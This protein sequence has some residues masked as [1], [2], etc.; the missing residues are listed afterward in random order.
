[1][2]EPDDIPYSHKHP[3]RMPRRVR[4]IDPEKSRP[5]QRVGPAPYWKRPVNIGYEQQKSKC[6]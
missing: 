6:R 5:D 3:E 1:M 4:D 2:R